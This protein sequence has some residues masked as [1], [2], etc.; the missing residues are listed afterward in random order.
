MALASKHVDI[1]VRCPWCHSEI[2][3]DVHVMFLCD[4][5][6]TVW[7]TSRVNHLVQCT[8]NELPCQIF[9]RVFENGTREQWVEI[10]MICWSLWN[11]RNRWVWERNNGSVFGVRHSAINLLAEW[12]EAQVHDED[13]R[14]RGELGRRVWC[15]P[16][17]GWVKINIDAA[18]FLDGSID[19]GTVIRDSQAKFYRSQRSKNCRGLETKRG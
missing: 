2:E 9:T 1:D 14:L 7:L 10:T 5:A 17:E 12:K 18:V 4:F 19:V 6:R 16:K 13:R 3:T 11:R 15:P 8:M